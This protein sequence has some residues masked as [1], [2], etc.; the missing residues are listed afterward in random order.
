MSP[1]HEPGRSRT[2]V[3]VRRS[4]LGDEVCDGGE[5]MS[6]A[7]RTARDERGAATRESILRAAERL[8]AENGMYVVSNRRISEELGLGNSA[9]V[10]YHFGTRTELVRAIVRGHGERMEHLRASM[11][12]TPGDSASLRYWV[13]CLVRPMT[14]HLAESGGPTWYARFAAQIAADP[15]LHEIAHEDSLSSP[16]L[17]FALDGLNRCL[18][19]LPENVRTERWNMG[20]HLTT[21]MCVERE[22][23]IAEGTP[24]LHADWESFANGLIDAVVGLWLAPVTHH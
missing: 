21:H 15:T 24:T 8:F 2:L 5:V 13:A 3:G 23:A 10:T 9:A 7:S 22:R 1:G 6:V 14:E 17:W 11:V 16:S 20:R 19:E 18:P 12:A 4:E